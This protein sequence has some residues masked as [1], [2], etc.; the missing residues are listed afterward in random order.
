MSSK[1]VLGASLRQI[2]PEEFHGTLFRRPRESLSFLFSADRP[3]PDILLDTTVY[4]DALKDDLPQE[5]ES[6]LETERLW[7][8]TVTE[9]ELA[10][11]SGRLDPKRAETATIIARLAA[12]IEQRPAHRVLN[13]DREVWREAGIL[14]GI[15]ARL[16]GYGKDQ[17][18]RALNDALIF[19]TAAKHGCAVLTRNLSDFD[20]LMQLDRR[21]M[22]LF[23]DRI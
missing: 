13:P 14:A 16:Q 4:V 11:F 7:H 18:R 2:R 23:Y 6:A 21:G 15:L 5:V 1:S 19:L 20:L 12:S 22:A 9:S 17:Q 3:I 10:V 8:I